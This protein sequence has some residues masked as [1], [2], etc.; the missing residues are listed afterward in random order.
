MSLRS[1]LT[2]V[3]GLA[4]T[5]VAAVVAGALTAVTPTP[6]AHADP[7]YDGLTTTPVITGLNTPVNF[8]FAPQGR[9]YVSE[10]SGVVKMYD[11]PGDG[12]PT[13]VIDLRRETFG[14]G[15]RGM[16]GLSLDPA[17][18]QGRPYLYLLMSYDKDPFGDGTVPRW[19]SATGGDTCATPPGP[20]D[21]GCTT[22]GLLLRYTL[23]P[24]GTADP[25]TRTV[26]LDGTTDPRG[27]WCQQFSSHSIGDVQFGPDGMLYVGAGD[28][29]SFNS[30]DYGQYGGSANSPTPANPCNDK[31]GARGTPLTPADSRGGALRTQAVRGA[32]TDG[33]VS[34]N[35]AILRID[36]DTGAAA[37]GNPL[38]D[39]GIAG[40]DRIVA[41]GLRNPYR[42]GFRPNTQQLWLGDVGWGTYEE[43][44]RF[45]T[46]P[47]QSS[48]PN[49][50]WPCYEGPNRQGNY[51]NANIGLCEQLYAQGQQSLGGV[52]SPLQAPYYAWA[53]DGAQ[54]AP[55]CSTQG[56]GSATGGRFVTNPAW[57]APLRGA[58]VF[59]D[60]ARGCI[61]ALPIVNGEPSV[62][63]RVVL[64]TG[65]PA[66]GFRT[67]PGGD[68][69]YV[70][71][72][73]GAIKRLRPSASN[74]PPEAAFTATPT[75]GDAPLT[76]AFDA[77]ATSDPDG[78]DVTLTWDLDGDGDCDDATGV[79]T[80]RT[81]TQAGIVT[82]KLC[83]TDA[84]GQQDSATQVI[85]VGN[86]TPPEVEVTVS[87]ADTRWAVGDTL[88]FTATGTDAED[89]TLPPSAYQWEFQQRHCVDEQESSCHTHAASATVNG[90]TATL[91][92]PDHEYFAY[93]RAKVTVTDSAGATDTAQVDA[94]P[95]V[96]TI[97]VAS[98][99]SGIPVTVGPQNGPTPKTAKFLENGVAQLIAPTTTTVDGVEYRFA[100][101][102]DGTTAANRE[103]R[104]PAGATTYTARY[105]A[106]VGTAPTLSDVTADPTFVTVRPISP[107]TV[108]VT[109]RVRD[110]K[111]IS[112]VIGKL[113]SPTGRIHR[114]T[115]L[116]ESGTATDGVYSGTIR[117]T[118]ANSQPGLH[119]SLVIATD[120]DGKVRRR[121]GPEVRVQ[122]CFQKT[123]EGRTG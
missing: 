38:L 49:F 8:D 51:D 33:Y 100:G 71:I 119:S 98:Q 109:A 97:T 52:P 63:D 4:G 99:P 107:Q 18:D 115:L 9:I 15:D 116:R 40:D 121:S 55:G 76:V 66:V 91:V 85:N 103:V 122:R 45:Q 120:T 89:G 96:S 43:L 117:L 113:T 101:W 5:A 79:A 64:V 53:R 57:P 10:K 1:S 59:S 26:L 102:A 83:A 105:T 35:G 48:V 106:V 77:G 14:Q 80:T 62:A 11:G 68:I 92:A 104:A 32:P 24:N 27:G 58:Y 93:I 12:T 78:D 70:D 23:R 69:Y 44:N 74:Q 28:G 17:L 72:A 82:V 56:G 123:C 111:G 25:A 34:W 29:A 39:N 20:N 67:G 87:T 50:G 75:S 60:Y 108:R 46:G 112:T 47:G 31:P 94:L 16:L 90:D 81:Y 61:V 36:P 95:R 84:T 19:G 65:E 7:V 110:D 21:D 86:D 73:A 22:S 42:F 37:P 118:Y 88:T 41:Y 2:P 30:V 6:S 3:R 114:A 13:Q 54:P